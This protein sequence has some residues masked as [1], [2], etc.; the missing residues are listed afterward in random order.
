MHLDTN[1]KKKILLL[2]LVLILILIIEILGF[3]YILN[4]YNKHLTDNDIFENDISDNVIALISITPTDLRLAPTEY[5]DDND[6][7]NNDDDNDDN[8]DNDD[9]D[10]NDDNSDIDPT[11]TQTPDDVI[12]YTPSPSPSSSPVP[13]PESSTA[14]V[15]FYADPQSDSDSE[16]V[17]HQRV[18]DYI[19]ARGA[20][21]V[22]NAGDLLEDGTQ[23]S[24]DRFNAVTSTLRSSRTFYSALGNN[25]R[26]EGDSST[27]SQIYL[28]N[29]SFPNNERW[30]SLN[31][32]NLHMVVLDSAFASTSQTQK[33]WLQ[34][35]LQS[36]NSQD[37]ITGVMFHHPSYASTISSYLT[38]N[39]VDFVVMGHEHSFRYYDS[40]GIDHFVSS[41]QT[42]MGYFTLRVYE[43]YATLSAYNSSNG[44]VGT[45]NINDR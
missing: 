39:N 40:N 8:S 28:D 30:Y 31:W 25:D 43:S 24:L 4:K 37:R 3:S 19:L 33:D 9:D 7:G 21:P 22:F 26:V 17:N 1:K 11:V 6:N 13:T 27:P 20:N 5:F 23:A 45:Y 14:Y 15:A 10:N 16:D 42:S 29:F 32:G 18:V 44:L 41:G 12:V 36:A 35:D 2:V 34:A 38:N